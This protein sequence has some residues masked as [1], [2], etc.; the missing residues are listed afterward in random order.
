MMTPKDIAENIIAG[1]DRSIAYGGKFLEPLAT[2][3]LA[4][5]AAAEADRAEIAA[6]TLRAVS[7]E[8]IRD[9]LDDLQREAVEVRAEI[10]RLERAL[11]SVRDGNIG[12]PWSASMCREIA[13]RATDAQ[14]GP[15][16]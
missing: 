12:I 7:A 13:V 15:K 14:G 5:R 6:L 2:D 9:T 8:L 11:V 4:L 3:Y 16:A 10:E 1:R